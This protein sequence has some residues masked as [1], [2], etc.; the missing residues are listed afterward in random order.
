MKNVYTAYTKVIQDVTFYFVKKFTT[1]PELSGVPDFLEN[2]GMHKD[3]N[4]ACKIAGVSD[5]SVKKFLL[6]EIENSEN[7]TK[8]IQMNT[9]TPLISKIGS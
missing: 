9:N 3:F 1:F 4:E 2:F 8:V 6:S 7:D 5:E